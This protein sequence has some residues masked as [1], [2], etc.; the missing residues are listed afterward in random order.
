VSPALVLN[1]EHEIS[2]RIDTS[3]DS[4]DPFYNGTHC[5]DGS[6][7][8][9]F[10]TIAVLIL[11]AAGGTGVLVPVVSDQQDGGDIVPINDFDSPVPHLLLPVSTAPS[12]AAGLARGEFEDVRVSDCGSNAFDHFRVVEGCE[13]CGCCV[14]VAAIGASGAFG[15]ASIG[16]V[17]TL[18]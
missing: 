13:E 1:P 18:G 17:A 3:F 5:K 11:I 4:I 6:L 12:N 9:T 10:V 2:T 15:I 16:A 7:G 14:A 8:S